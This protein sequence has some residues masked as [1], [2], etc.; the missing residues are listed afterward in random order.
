MR[1]TR[2]RLMK[3][4]NAELKSQEEIGVPSGLGRSAPRRDRLNVRRS[5][6]SLGKYSPATTVAL[7]FAISRFS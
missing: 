3:F 2:Q 4:R 1:R 5:S 7:R 6:G